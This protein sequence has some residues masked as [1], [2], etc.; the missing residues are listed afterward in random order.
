MGAPKPK[1]V[2]IPSELLVK[3]VPE[4]AARG[5]DNFQFPNIF[6]NSLARQDLGFR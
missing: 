3:V 2:Q 6:D 5:G 4:R 1:L